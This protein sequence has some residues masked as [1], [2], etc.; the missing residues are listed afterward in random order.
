MPGPSA[1]YGDERESHMISRHNQLLRGFF[2]SLHYVR[3]L[4]SD[5]RIYVTTKVAPDGCSDCW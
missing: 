1:W 4:S 5:A 2:R 3:P